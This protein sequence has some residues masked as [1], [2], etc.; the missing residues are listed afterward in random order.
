MLSIMSMGLAQRA[1]GAWRGYAIYSFVTLA[2]V[3]ITGGAAAA[4]AAVGSPL[5]GLLE[6]ATIGAFLQWVF[7]MAWKMLRRLR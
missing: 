7:V 2:V 1:I 3:F 6:R 4:G 5:M